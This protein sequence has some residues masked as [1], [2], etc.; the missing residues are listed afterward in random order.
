[1]S[2]KRKDK[3]CFL[4]LRSYVVGASLAGTSAAELEDVG[5]DIMTVGVLK[6]DLLSSNRS[7]QSSEGKSINI[8]V[9]NTHQCHL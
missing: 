3:A 8:C 6:A 5:L 7:F 2:D 1:M 4:P 9:C